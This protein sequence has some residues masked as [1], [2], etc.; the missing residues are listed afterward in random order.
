MKWFSTT[1]IFMYDFKS[2]VLKVFFFFLNIVPSQMIPYKMEQREYCLLYLCILCGN[3]RLYWNHNKYDV[4]RLRWKVVL[5]QVP[6]Y[7]KWKKNLLEKINFSRATTHLTNTMEK[8]KTTITIYS[9]QSHEWDLRRVKYRQTLWLFCK[10]SR[11][12]N[13]AT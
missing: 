6:G 3:I 13:Q 10:I 2:Q 5:K 12:K 4:H 1:H 7:L 11:L 8:W 9:V